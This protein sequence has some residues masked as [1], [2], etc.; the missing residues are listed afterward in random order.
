MKTTVKNIFKKVN[1][2]VPVMTMTVSIMYICMA[3]QEDNSLGNASLISNNQGTLIQQSTANPP[4]A[5]N[6][7]GAKKKA[8]KN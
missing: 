1:W 7:N 3:Y 6:I 5:G 4:I 2:M 8:T